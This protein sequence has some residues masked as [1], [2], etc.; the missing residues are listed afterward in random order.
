[1]IVGGT[2]DMAQPGARSERELVEAAMGGSADAFGDLAA[3]ASPRLYAVAR[4]I[5]H[6]EAAADDATQDALVAAWRDLSA[7]RDPDHFGAW[8]HRVL[9]RTC[10]RTAHRAR[11]R[12][13]I[14]GQVRP[15][16]EPRDPCDASV[17]KDE[18]ERGFS[19]LSVEHRTVL[20]LHHYLGYTFP[21]IAEVLGIPVGTAKSRIHRASAAMR[22]AISSDH[23]QQQGQV[24]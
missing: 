11:R 6:D 8:L 9:V 3:A 14:E 7:L 17:L 15:I 1:M 4:L 24:A 18:I 22:D 10:Y 23:Q 16:G 12:I 2:N 20:V 13:E 21:E 5:L 19:R